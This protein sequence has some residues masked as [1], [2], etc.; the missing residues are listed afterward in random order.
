MTDHKPRRSHLHHLSL[1]PVTGGLVVACLALVA[2]CD[3][4][5]LY[6]GYYNSLFRPVLEQSFKAKV[7][8]LGAVLKRHVQQL[9]STENRQ[10][11]FLFGCGKLHCPT[12]IFVKIVSS[13]QFPLR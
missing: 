10:V 3:G 6:D 9:R 4:F 5:R 11:S 2:P 1:G 12:A 7:E 13:D 8:T